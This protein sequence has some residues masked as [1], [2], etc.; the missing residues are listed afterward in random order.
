MSQLEFIAP[1][2][3]DRLPETLGVAVLGCGYWGAN[4]VRVFNDLPSTRVTLAC[5]I[6]PDRLQDVRRRFPS[7]PTTPNLG[8]VLASPDVD[9]VVVCTEATS[10]Y[11][12]V[13]Q[14]LRAGKH[15]LVEKPI[16]TSA[17]D[18]NV[19]RQL[20]EDTGLV[21]MVSHTFLYNAGI[22]AVKD[23]M[24]GNDVGRIYYLYASRTNLGPI[25]RDVNA[26]WDLAPHDVAIFNYLLDSTPLWASAV[27]VKALRNGRED[28]GFVS[29]GYPDDIV[30]HIHVSWADPWKVREVVV[31]ASNQRIAFNDLNTLEQVRVFEKSVTTVEN[32]SAQEEY[33]FLMRNGAIVSPPIEAAEPLKTEA[34]HFVECVTHGT[35]P[36]SG[37]LEGLEVVRAMEAITTSL[38]L[39]G[40]PVYLGSADGT[41]GLRGTETIHS[42]R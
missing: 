37:A 14:C 28:V 12:I 15:V 36:L 32:E 39:H 2:Y 7:I 41:Y 10:H 11:R 40:A 30:G 13:Q 25:R 19:L 23:H 20:S 16:T 1:T 34:N 35:R 29:L 33:P 31:V 38:G 24:G 22:R 4:Y 5:D 3:L 8:D 21:L 18:A 9:A 27:G 26:L 42:V 17:E 6:S